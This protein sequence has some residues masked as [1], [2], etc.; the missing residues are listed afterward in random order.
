MPHVGIGPVKLGAARADSRNALA[1]AGFPLTHSRES[2]DYFCDSSIQIEYDADETVS[3]IGVSHS[4]RF[5]L[6]FLD[7]NVFACAAEGL[8]SLIANADQSGLHTYTP[9]EYCFPNQIVTLYEA[10]QESLGRHVLQRMA[11]RARVDR[12]LAAARDR[13]RRRRRGTLSRPL[14]RGAMQVASSPSLRGRTRPAWTGRTKPFICWNKPS[15][16]ATG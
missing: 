4:S 13:K 2:M 7:Q 5:K 10:V 3:F 9:N 8:F 11:S 14:R 12:D 15:P 16:S 6:T 1:A